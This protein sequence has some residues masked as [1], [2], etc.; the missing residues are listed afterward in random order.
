VLLPDGTVIYGVPQQSA[1]V[2]IVVATP[3]APA[4]RVLRTV[5]FSSALIGAGPAG[6]LLATSGSHFELMPLDGSAG[7][8]FDIPDVS[9]GPA[10]DGRTI[11]WARRTCVTTAISSWTLGTAA[12]PLRDL[13]CPTPRPSRS[14]VTLPRDRRLGVSLSCPASARG[15]CLAGV[16]LTAI[17]RGRLSRGANGAERS[18]RLGSVLVALDPGEVARA[19]LLV[20]P[21]A[22]RWVRRHAPLRLRIEARSDRTASQRPPGEPAVVARTV[23]L[24]RAR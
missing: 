5:S 18:Y 16:R 11:T 12:P 17:R 13:R 9:A 1:G 14:A 24:R 10:F 3:A 7:R 2:P 19:E 6:V 22:A 4:G 21:G 23:S 15:G 8:G 20:P